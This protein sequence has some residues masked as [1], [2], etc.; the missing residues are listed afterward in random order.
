[1][2]RRRSLLTISDYQ[3]ALK[4]RYGLGTGTNYKPWLRVQ[5]VPSRGTST[6]IQG[7]KSGRVHHLLSEGE[8]CC[9]YQAEFLD[10]VVDIREQFPL[11]P[12]PLMFSIAETI[13]VSY[14]RV[15]STKTPVVM[16]TD[17]L[18]T[19]Q[20]DGK[21]W[22]EAIS[23]K[24]EEYLSDQRV[25]EKLDVERIWWELLGI[26]F[27]VF[28]PSE[29]GKIQARNIEWITSPLRQGVVIPDKWIEMALP[30]LSVG[31]VLIFDL[32]ELLSRVVDISPNEAQHLFRSLIA[33]KKIK[34]NMNQSIVDT[35]T[36]T[37]IWVE[38]PGRQVE[39]CDGY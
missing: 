39:V 22:Y 34:V 13:G 28:I 25:A 31:P 29:E 38:P 3:R 24:P 20:T 37:L 19:C 7:I 30:H 35:G 6:K 10:R 4:N 32:C 8:S 14:P 5:D 16:T 26:S 27:K 11:L 1:M 21:I 2:G 15:P 23:V 33:A 17:L 18:L 12:L 9:F 36:I